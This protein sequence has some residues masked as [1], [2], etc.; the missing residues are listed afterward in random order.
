M[1]KYPSNS[2]FQ[3]EYILKLNVKILKRKDVDVIVLFIIR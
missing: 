2:I 1:I 3:F